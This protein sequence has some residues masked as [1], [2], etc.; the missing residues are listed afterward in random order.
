MVQ[1]DTTAVAPVFNVVAFAGSL[2]RGSYGLITLH[3]RTEARITA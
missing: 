3:V 2:R 1:S